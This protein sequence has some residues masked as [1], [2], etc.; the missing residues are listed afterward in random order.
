MGGGQSTQSVSVSSRLA[1]NAV[2]KTT[3][4]CMSA[5][6]GKQVI[7]VSGVGNVVS[8]NRQKM[9]MSVDAECVQKATQK[10]NFETVL[11][12]KVAQ[13]MS[14]HTVAMTEWMD[15]THSDQSTSIANDVSIGITQATVQKS[16]Q[17][18]S[19]AQ[20]IIVGGSGNVV[21]ANVQDFT[22]DSVMRSL[23]HDDKSASAIT[24]ITNTANQHQVHVSENPL[25][26]ITDFLSAMLTAPLKIL[27]ML[28]IGL[29]AF[30]I[31]I[32]M[33]R[34]GRRE[35]EQR[36]QREQREHPAAVG[37]AVGEVR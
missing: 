10:A 28:F 23:Q 19:G 24:K 37:A 26:F 22:A 20:K 12:N 18:L 7:D 1:A 15:G 36:E 8:G 16:V 17:A 4:D 2:L 32:H 34:H 35:R 21:Q 13:S 33:I 30:I 27:A 3:Q 25:A 5:I 6:V 29:I 9:T 31:F 11:G 14:S